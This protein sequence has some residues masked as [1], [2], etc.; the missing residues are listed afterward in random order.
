MWVRQPKVLP[1]FV[2]KCLWTDN[3]AYSWHIQLGTKHIGYK[4]IFFSNIEMFQDSLGWAIAVNHNP[5]IPAY[6]TFHVAFN[7][8]HTPFAI[9]SNTMSTLGCLPFNLLSRQPSTEA[10]ELEEDLSAVLYSTPLKSSVFTHI[11]PS[12]NLIDWSISNDSD[13]TILL[14]RLSPG[15][16]LWGL[17]FDSNAIIATRMYKYTFLSCCNPGTTFAAN[18]PKFKNNASNFIYLNFINS[19]SWKTGLSKKSVSCL[20]LIL[21][22]EITCLYEDIWI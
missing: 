22:V 10:L 8:N 20:A 21:M 15:P 14:G 12:P 7:W 19:S 6:T 18:L 16:L 2:G 17:L 4:I 1:S 5:T 11:N 13:V 9:F 3:L